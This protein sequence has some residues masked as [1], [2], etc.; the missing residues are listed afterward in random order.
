MAYDPQFIAG[1]DIPLPALAPRIQAV[2]FNGGLPIEHSRF[3]I[4]FNQDRGFAAVTAHNIDGDALIAKGVIKRKDS[5]RFDTKAPNHIQIDNDQGY[6]G[7]PKP[8]NNPWDRGHLVRRRSM[9]WGDEA[10]ARLADKESYFWT[11]IVPQH[12]KLHDTAWGKIEDFMLKTAEDADKRACVFQGP[13]LTPDDPF[14]TNQPGEDPFQ[15]PAG[16]WKIFCVKHQNKLRA[17][18]FLV[19]Q[20]DFDDLEMTFDPV[21]E[22]VRITTIEYLS[23]LAF[24]RDVREADPLRFSLSGQPLVAGAQ[25]A[26]ARAAGARAPV[27][28]APRPAG[29]A[30][31]SS[32]D[33]C[34]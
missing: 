10:E 1:C 6:K 19:W 26:S 34:L 22:Q 2:A 8:K 12:E 29:G 24:T 25:A 16:F 23:G 17:A 20:R 32:E 7:V 13:V 14:H 15:L 30:I 11:N 5:F 18:C 28:A 4:I 31:R 21:L 27:V 9:H 33:I 3:S